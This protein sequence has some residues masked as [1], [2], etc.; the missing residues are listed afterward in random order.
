LNKEAIDTNGLREGILPGCCELAAASVEAYPEDG[1]LLI[2]RFFPDAQT[3]LVVGH[4]IEASLEW[5][6]FPF[7]AERGGNTCAADLHA[8]SMTEA[9]GR[10]LVSSGHKSVLLPYPDGCGISFKR[11]A[12]RTGMGELGESF[13][14]LH[15]AWGPWV[16]LRALLTDVP[17]AETERKAGDLC[18]HCGK[19]KEACPGKA[20]SAGGHDQNAC[21]QCQREIRD[22]LLIQAEYRFKCE[23]CVRA[24]PVGE[25]PREI[26]IGDKA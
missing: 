14:F 1:K 16:H 26:V 22:R 4:H 8:K 11:L 23:A 24:C 19:C 13:L 10:R 5:A 18:T 6:W 3:V 21:G 17:I 25:A 12:A 7:T 2:R 20:L 15:H 9:I